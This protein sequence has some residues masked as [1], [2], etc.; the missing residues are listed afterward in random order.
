MRKTFN[1][2]DHALL[3]QRLHQ[4]SICSTEIQWLSSYLSDHVQRVKCNHSYFAGDLFWEE[5]PKGVSA[6]GL[7]YFDLCE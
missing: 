7:L 4:L 2:H 1:S 3:L 6:L 5:F